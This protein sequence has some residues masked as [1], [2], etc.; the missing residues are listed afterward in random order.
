MLYAQQDDAEH[1][2]N[3]LGFQHSCF[4]NS[5]WAELFCILCMKCEA[6]ECNLEV[7]FVSNRFI[8]RMWYA[9]TRVRTDLALE[10]T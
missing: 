4:Q 7:I 3:T 8:L 9:P 2:W 6:V 10:S 1:V 5:L